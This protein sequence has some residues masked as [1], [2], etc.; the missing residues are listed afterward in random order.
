MSR[1]LFQLM[2]IIIYEMRMQWRRRNVS[3]L[4]AGMAALL[5]F[6]TVLLGPI[7]SYTY[8]YMGPESEQP[9]VLLSVASGT[10]LAA[11]LLVA[12]A[13]PL[14]VADTIPLDQQTGAREL[15]DSLPLNWAVYLTGKLLSVW[16]SLSLGMVGVA[17]LDGLIGRPFH[18]PERP[19][20]YLILWTVGVAPMVLFV[21]GLSVLLAVG[22]PTRRRAVFVGVIVAVCASSD[23][24]VW[25]RLGLGSCQLDPTH[26]LHLQPVHHHP[27]HCA[28]RLRHRA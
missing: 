26:I 13:V 22:Q 14:V 8:G 20:N 28:E 7:L 9:R 3:V 27:E 10:W 23:D 19:E 11:I 6:S 15:L 18:G 24:G 4:L 25:D 21:A 5:I 16:I 12:L 2:G 1:P 17:L